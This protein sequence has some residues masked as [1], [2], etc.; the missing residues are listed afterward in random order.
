MIH[1]SA[2]LSIDMYLKKVA[3]GLENTRQ[4]KHHMEK[5]LKTISKIQHC[6]KYLIFGKLPK[7]YIIQN[8]INDT[9]LNTE[10]YLS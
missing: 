5:T 2:V 3:L 10:T 9:R 6:P 4:N 7:V 1:K 8:Y